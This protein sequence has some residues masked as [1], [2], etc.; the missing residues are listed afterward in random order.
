MT[1]AFV[2]VVVALI[3]VIYRLFNSTIDLKMETLKKDL[4]S[5]LNNGLNKLRLEIEHCRNDKNLIES[6]IKSINN[7]KNN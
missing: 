6:I 2:A 4:N 5:E 7:N 1:T 3:G